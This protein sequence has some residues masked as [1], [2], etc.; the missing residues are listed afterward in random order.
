[1]DI[2]ILYKR[3]IFLP[4]FDNIGKKC[5]NPEFDSFRRVK[6]LEPLFYKG[7]ESF[8]VVKNMRT[9]YFAIL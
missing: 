4:Q 7:L 2:I 8:F 9:F 6:T 3:L 1:M 5:Y